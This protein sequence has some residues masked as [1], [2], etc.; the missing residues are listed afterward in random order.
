MKEVYRFAKFAV[1]GVSNTLLTLLTYWILVYIGIYYVTAN[2]V[3]YMV[4]M[5]NSYFWNS[6]YVFER[7]STHSST[8]TKFI[9][10]NLIVLGLT[11]VMLYFFIEKIYI[12]KYL[13]QLIVIPAGMVLNYILN[14]IWTFRKNEGC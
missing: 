6:K 11:S 3:G 12:N 7:T 14:K 9:I 8:I 5:A 10:V 13:A 1:V 2:I 4:G